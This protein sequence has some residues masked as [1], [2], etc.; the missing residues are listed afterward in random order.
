M[1]PMDKATRLRELREGRTI[2]TTTIQ[3]DQDTKGG[4]KGRGSIVNLEGWYQARRKE[5][6][7]Y[8][9]CGCGRTSSKK[10]DENF[11]ASIAHIVPKSKCRSVATHPLNWV[12][13]NFWD[14]CHSNMDEMGSDRWPNMA[15]WPTIVHRFL[16][17]YLL[18]PVKERRFIPKVLQDVIADHESKS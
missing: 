7:G 11:R 3:P 1:Q 15:C 12:E 6:T 4:K 2:Q 16:T 17:F 18:I 8:C 10:D 5:M 9:E 14:G 13:M